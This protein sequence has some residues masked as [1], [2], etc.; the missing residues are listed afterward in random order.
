MMSHVSYVLITDFGL[1]DWSN[2][3]CCC[4]KLLS[5]F[6]VCSNNLAKNVRWQ[7]LLGSHHQSF[8]AFLERVQ[9]FPFANRVMDNKH[10]AVLLSTIG[11]ENYICTFEKRTGKGL[12]KEKA[13]AD[14]RTILWENVVVKI[15]FIISFVLFRE[16]HLMY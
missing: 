14:I 6:L 9:F 16:K 3:C 13:S 11:E 15:S 1:M 12:P 4:A 7:Q 2:H 8:T 5:P 10:A